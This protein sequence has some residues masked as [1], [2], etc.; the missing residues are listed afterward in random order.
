MESGLLT[1]KPFDLT[2]NVFGRYS[3]NSRPLNSLSVKEFMPEFIDSNSNQLIGL[4]G[5][6]EINSEKKDYEMEKL[7]IEVLV[8]D[9]NGKADHFAIYQDGKHIGDRP[10]DENKK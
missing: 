6:Y 5:R 3:R 7:T 8:M 4:N 1:S 2:N 9:K 10:I